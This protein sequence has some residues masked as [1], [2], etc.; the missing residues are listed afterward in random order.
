M[1]ITVTS[2]LHEKST[3]QLGNRVRAGGYNLRTMKCHLSL[4]T[5]SAILIRVQMRGVGEVA[6][7]WVP[8]ASGQM[9]K[10]DIDGFFSTQILTS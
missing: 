6:G 9:F 4:L 7:C 5:N 8:Q 2:P 10:D 3:D 1:R